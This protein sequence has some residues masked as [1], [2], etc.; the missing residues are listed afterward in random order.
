ML[1]RCILYCNSLDLIILSFLGHYRS[2]ELVKAKIEHLVSSYK[3]THEKVMTTGEGI[4]SHHQFEK[5]M[6]L[7]TKDIASGIPN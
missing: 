7:Y 1:K 3:I 5:F 4:D 6:S 2:S